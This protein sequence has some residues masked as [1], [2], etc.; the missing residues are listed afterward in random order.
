M[1][2]NKNDFYQDFFKGIAH[3]GLHNEKYTENGLLAF[4]NAIDNDFAFEFDIHLTKDNKLVVMHDSNLIR[5]TGKEGIIEE[6]TL[7]EIQNN[8][9]LLDGEKIPTLDDVLKLN[10]ERNT[11]VIELKPFNKNSKKLAL[12]ASQALKS[13]KDKKKVTIISFDPLSLFYI[14][15]EPFKRGILLTSSRKKSLFFRNFFEYLDIDMN[16]L[17][18]QKIK[19]YKKHHGLLNVWTI[20]S[21]EDYKKVLKKVD[22]ITFENLDVDFVKKLYK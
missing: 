12:I 9:K 16:L 1:K 19:K 15:K 13:I 17:D 14:K 8:Y 11:M 2:A 3:R 4:K 6:L 7:N 20:R 18:N 21:E 10:N 5:T 22:T